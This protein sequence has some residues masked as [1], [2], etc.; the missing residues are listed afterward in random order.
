ML[1]SSFSPQLY[2]ISEAYLT[3][4]SRSSGSRKTEKDADLQEALALSLQ[5]DS[6][7]ISLQSVLAA[8]RREAEELEIQRALRIST[9]VR[10][11]FRGFSQ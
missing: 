8:T 10:L 9:Q 5:D 3:Q 11:H 1:S 4:P 7:D 6:N 2:P